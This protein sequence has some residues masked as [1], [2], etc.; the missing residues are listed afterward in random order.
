[1]NSVEKRLKIFVKTR[2]Y[3]VLLILTGSTCRNR[4]HEVEPRTNASIFNYIACLTACRF[5]GNGN[6]YQYIIPTG[7]IFTKNH[8]AKLK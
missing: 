4:W 6:F 3:L 7:F 1:M 2:F 5:G 8:N